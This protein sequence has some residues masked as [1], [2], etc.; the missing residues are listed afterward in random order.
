MALAAAY[1]KALNA[2]PALTKY[3]TTFWICCASV[4][5]SQKCASFSLFAQLFVRLPS[6]RRRGLTARRAV[7][8]R[9]AGSRTR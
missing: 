9:V 1:M 3:C 7:R 2:A 8:A 6:G 4:Y 5:L